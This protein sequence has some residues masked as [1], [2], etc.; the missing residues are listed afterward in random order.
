MVPL[1]SGNMHPCPLPSPSALL[2]LPPG[3][4]GALCFDPP[5]NTLGF[6]LSLLVLITAIVYM[7]MHCMG[8]MVQPT[9]LLGLCGVNCSCNCCCGISISSGG[10][11]G[12]ASRATAPRS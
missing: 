7:V 4:L 3:S 1:V 11:G 6:V 2:P 12:G 5:T 8:N 9:P 10:S